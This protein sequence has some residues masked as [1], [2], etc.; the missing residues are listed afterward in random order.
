VLEALEVAEGVELLLGR[1]AVELPEAEGRAEALLVR[2]L[3]AVA[4]MDGEGGSKPGAR[5]LSPK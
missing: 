1:L 5:V 4:E 2:L 3:R